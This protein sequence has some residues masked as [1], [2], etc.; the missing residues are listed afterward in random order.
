MVSGTIFRKLKNSSYGKPIMRG[1]PTPREPL[2]LHG[3][4]LEVQC[5]NCKGKGSVED[6][7]DGRK[8]GR[9]CVVCG[10]RG[11]ILNES[12]RAVLMLV[13]D[14]LKADGIDVLIAKPE[15]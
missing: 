5:D 2:T 6:E 9:T 14:Y 1:S 8:G 12:G 7:R 4:K 11:V 13:S 10:G 3:F 15:Y